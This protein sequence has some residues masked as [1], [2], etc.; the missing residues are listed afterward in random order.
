MVNR[1]SPRRSVQPLHLA[2]VARACDVMDTDRLNRLMS[3][4]HHALAADAFIDE[5]CLVNDSVVIHHPAVHVY[6]A[7]FAR[8]NVETLRISVLEMAIRH[9]HVNVL[10]QAEIEIHIH[11]VAVER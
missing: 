7:N 2:F 4:S 6:R 10:G 9:K 5:G 8:C 3:H 11:P 1:Q